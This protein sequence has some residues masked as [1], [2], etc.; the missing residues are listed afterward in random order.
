L[1][2]NPVRRAVHKNLQK[3]F[4]GYF[5]EA[6]GRLSPSILATEVEQAIF[7][8]LAMKNDAGIRTGGAEY[9]DKFRSL[10]FNLK[11][12]K[13]EQLR[14][15]L[16]TG[17]LKASDLVEM[18]AEEL[19]NSD[20]QILREQEK[21][22]SLKDTIKIA[23]LDSLPAESSLRNFFPSEYRQQ[24]TKAS[25]IFFFFFLLFILF[26]SVFVVLKTTT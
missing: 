16:F 24:E 9:K 2:E 13:N 6:E 21:Q 20:L 11:D 3:V 23:D 10:E 26:V 25:G 7:N 19:A 15:R 22:R 17:E 4:E 12:A 14:E 18:S 1:A 5:R 8:R